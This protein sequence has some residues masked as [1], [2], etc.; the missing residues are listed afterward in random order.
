MHRLLAVQAQDARGVRLAVRSRSVGLHATDVDDALNDG[1][2]LI[3]WV[4]RGTLH[5]VGADD[6]WRLH[7]LTTPQL[8][9][10]QSAATPARGRQ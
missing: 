4:N 10:R 9:D 8:V 7:P 3:T 6:Y 2:L 5:L 1:R